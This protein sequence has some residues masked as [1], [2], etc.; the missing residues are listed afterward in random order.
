MKTT[1]EEL[2]SALS[3]FV[4][5]LGGHSKEDDKFI[6]LVLNDHRTN[7]QSTFRL[8]V[9]LMKAWAAQEPTGNFD[10]RNEATV[11]ACAKL[12]ASVEDKELYLPYI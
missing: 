11:K 7:Q 8:M 6:A 12:I 2:A 10:Q 9:K 3:D 5:V 1:P 4:N